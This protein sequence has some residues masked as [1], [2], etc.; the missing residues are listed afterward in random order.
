M[1]FRT[2][3]ERIKRILQV[4]GT[5]SIKDKILD[6]L[7]HSSRKRSRLQIR[8]ESLC[9]EKTKVKKIRGQ[10]LRVHRCDP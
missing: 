8:L 6:G 5:C 2:L 7:N 4:C 1:F 10:R 3:I 9:I